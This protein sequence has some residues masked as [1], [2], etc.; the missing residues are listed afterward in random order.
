MK[1]H[2]IT[3]PYKPVIAAL[4]FSF[5]IISC[6]KNHDSVA[7]KPLQVE[8]TAI[9]GNAAQPVITIAANAT[10]PPTKTKYNFVF[11][12]EQAQ[13][14]PVAPGQPAVPVPWSNQVTRNYDPGL[15]YDFKKSD[16]WE[17]VYNSFSDSLNSANRFFILYNK[18]RGVI[19]YYTYN[20]MESNPSVTNFRS[21]ING[22]GV[23]GVAAGSTHILNFADQL[24]V[25]MNTKSVN[26]SLIEPW[27]I[28]QNAWYLSQFE[29]AYDPNMANFNWQQFQLGWI[30]NFAR[31]M[32]LSLNSKPAG[33][34]MLFLQKPGLNFNDLSARG[35]AIGSNMQAHVKSAGGLDELSGIFSGSV[36]SNLKQ[37]LFDSAAGNKLNA[38]LVPQLG[39]ADCKLDVPALI[40][41]DYNLVGYIPGLTLALPGLDNTQVIGFAPVFN[42]PLGIFYLGA[43][44]IIQ[45]TKVGGPLSEQYTLDIASIEYIINPFIQNYAAV[46]NFHQEIVAVAGNE[47]SNLTEAKLYQGQQLKASAPLTILGVRVSFEV[48]PKSG[49]APIRI[50]KTFKA[51]LRNS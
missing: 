25:D 14:M 24:I 4:I 27:P 6:K 28:I 20:E 3:L 29:I 50:I 34:K 37:T 38:T 44:P 45:H 7:E 31:I 42:E 36:I 8:E 33:N 47:T 39:I 22:I 23:Y 11:D 18:F 2:L 21:L 1:K 5:T 43:P 9:A 19:R 17:L 32:E 35:V 30:F 40:R 12:W 10:V 16:G 51:D 15:R 48:L 41:L 46:R 13:Y 49:T 26:A